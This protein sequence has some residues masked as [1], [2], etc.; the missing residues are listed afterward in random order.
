MATQNS[1]SEAQQV[2]HAGPDQ[3]EPGALTNDR[4]PHRV[5]PIALRD[6]RAEKNNKLT[7]IHNLKIQHK[8]KMQKCQNK[9]FRVQTNK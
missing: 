9:G 2:S 7:E 3:H 1:P 8:S 5:D 6:L 4:S